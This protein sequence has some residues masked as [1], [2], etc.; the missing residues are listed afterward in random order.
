MKIAIFTA[1]VPLKPWFD[2]SWWPGD[3]QGVG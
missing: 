3:F 1:L 2:K